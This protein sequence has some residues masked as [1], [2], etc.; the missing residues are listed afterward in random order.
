LTEKLGQTK[1]EK[2]SLQ[3]KLESEF[4]SNEK[5]NVFIPEIKHLLEL[6]R[7]LPTP[8][9]KNDILKEVLEKVVYT[10]TVNGRWHNQADEFSLV[11][12]PKFPESH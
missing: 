1:V 7:L 4:N 6:Y 8:Q 9:T 5:K 12:Y 11:L 2:T 10:K 3:K